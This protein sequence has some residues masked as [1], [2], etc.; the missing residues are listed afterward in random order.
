MTNSVSG[1]YATALF[2]LAK[3]QSQLERVEV[4][5]KKIQAMLAE[6]ADLRWM[7]KNPLFPAKDK[8]RALYLIMEKL[9]FSSITIKFVKLVVKN[10]RLLVLSDT[11]K[12]FLQL[13]AGARDEVQVDVTSAN[14]LTEEQVQVLKHMLAESTGK[15]VQISTHVNS[16][17]LGGLV[18]KIGSRMIDSSLRTKLLTLKMRMKEVG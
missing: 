7:I 16:S 6:S 17:L 12:S 8:S 4:D 2:E 1:R 10:Q 14:A 11:V 15:N 18:V 3:E 5:I 9:G 13:V